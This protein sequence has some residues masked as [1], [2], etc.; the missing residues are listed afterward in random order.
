MVPGRLMRQLLTSATWQ[1][2]CAARAWSCSQHAHTQ[3]GRQRQG[4]KA[5]EAGDIIGGCGAETGMPG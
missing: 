4:N 2:L 1:L 3:V 5:M